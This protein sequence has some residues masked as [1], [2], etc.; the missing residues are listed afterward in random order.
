[1][2][3]FAKIP[4]E[5]MRPRP[6]GVD[7]DGLFAT[8]AAVK[9]RPELADFQFRATNVWQ[10]GD[11]NRTAV[12]EFRGAGA[13]H[14]HAKPFLL[15]NAEPPVLLGGDTAANP[16]EHVLSALMGCLTT[17]MVYH[18]AARGIVINSIES[19][20]EGDLDLRGFLG[21]SNEVRKGFHHVRVRMTVA[22]A[23][24]VTVLRELAQYSP[25]YD[26]VSR[27]LP[28]EVRGRASPPRMIDSVS[29]HGAPRRAGGASRA[30]VARRRSEP[31]PTV[32]Q[33][34]C[35]GMPSALHHGAP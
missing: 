16:V 5:L 32:R 1:M 33:I 30:A 11:V 28:V 7:V 20:I 29:V 23:A 3:M 12:T 4:A 27:S 25:V 21:L 8:I 26:I 31:P 17:T 22:S 9:D 14:T 19:S 24:D 34:S 2:V 18:A 6:N 13:D 10:G 35:R 15:E